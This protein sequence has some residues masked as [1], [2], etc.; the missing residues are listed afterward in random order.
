MDS[1]EVKQH[2]STD[3]R[4]SELRSCVKVE[5]VQCCFASTETIGLIR[6]GESKTATSTPIQL[7]SS[8]EIE[9]DVL[10]SLIVRTVSVD[11][12]K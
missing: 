1:A 3:T 9:V 10:A 7:L 5:V 6:D 2:S 12:S 11:V 4:R 8:E